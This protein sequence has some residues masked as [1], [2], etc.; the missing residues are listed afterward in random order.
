MQVPGTRT[1]PAT[2]ISW[3]APATVSQHEAPQQ[4]AAVDGQRPPPH[5]HQPRVQLP[6]QLSPRR[7]PKRQGVS[8]LS[9]HTPTTHPRVQWRKDPAMVAAQNAKE[10]RFDFG[11]DPIP[12]TAPPVGKKDTRHKEREQ[13]RVKQLEKH[14][15]LRKNYAKAAPSAGQKAALDRARQRLALERQAA[16]LLHVA[17]NQHPLEK[18]C[19]WKADMEGPLLVIEHDATQPRYWGVAVDLVTALQRAGV[20]VKHFLANPRAAADASIAGGYRSYNRF[21]FP[22]GIRFRPRVGSFE[23]Y[24]VF[25]PSYQVRR[26]ICHPLVALDLQF[27]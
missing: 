18:Y 7:S 9:L 11:R 20:E 6:A 15:M 3:A 19:T 26:I 8:S 23:V 10:R 13:E 16:G 21:C 5:Q 2:N 25:P 22:D 14:R 24:L 12:R 4:L 1:Q 17:D 27:F